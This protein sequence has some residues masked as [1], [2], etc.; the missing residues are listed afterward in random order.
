LLIK[1]TAVGAGASSVLKSLNPLREVYKTSAYFLKRAH[2]PLDR[3]IVAG[4][5]PASARYV[6]GDRAEFFANKFRQS[7]VAEPANWVVE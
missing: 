4:H 6:T 1:V 5:R 2:D 3:I 7:R